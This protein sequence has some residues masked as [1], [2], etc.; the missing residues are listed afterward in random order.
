MQ[1]NK[2]GGRIERAIDEVLDKLRWPAAGLLFLMGLLTVVDVVGR[3]VFLK[4]VKGNIDIQELMMVVIIFLG[5]GYCTL[6]GRHAN[7]DV[8]IS[9]LSGH[10]QAIL[11]IIT[12]LLSAVIYGLISWQITK[13]GLG[14]ISSPTRA[15][16]LLAIKQGPYIL[17]A[18]LGS[19]TVC[20]ASLANVFRSLARVLA[21]EEHRA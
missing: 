20:V 3:Y 8:I 5:V 11:S 2:F 6:K 12:W 16:Y 10:T 9:R 15:S 14:E 4:P 13:W 7:A 19:I 17:V 1:V 18:A 21:G